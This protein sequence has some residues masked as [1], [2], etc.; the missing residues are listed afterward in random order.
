[1]VFVPILSHTP[2]AGIGVSKKLWT[3]QQFDS[4]ARAYPK[5][6][7][8]AVAS[9]PV[10]PFTGKLFY[11]DGV[12]E[13]SPFAINTGESFF[14]DGIV[15]AVPMPSPPATHLSVE[16]LLWSQGKFSIGSFL[17]WESYSGTQNGG[18]QDS[19]SYSYEPPAAPGLRVIIDNQVYTVELVEE[20]MWHYDETS[21]GAGWDQDGYDVYTSTVSS[22]QVKLVGAPNLSHLVIDKIVYFTNEV[23]P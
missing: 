17:S 2:P 15:V 7:P 8:A 21:V 14:S 13:G 9:Y 18:G 16:Q 1:M 11:V 6:V 4:A 5:P 12:L 19:Y 10:N 23:A 22:Y 20:G 3:P